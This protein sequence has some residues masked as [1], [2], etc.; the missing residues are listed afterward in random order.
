MDCPISDQLVP[1]RISRW[2]ESRDH[3]DSVHSAPIWPGTGWIGMLYF[4]QMRECDVVLYRGVGV[5]VHVGPG[6]VGLMAVA[7]VVEHA[8]RPNIVD[9]CYRYW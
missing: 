6:D 3:D 7:F 9:V 8:Q 1:S 4:F 5:P 2:L